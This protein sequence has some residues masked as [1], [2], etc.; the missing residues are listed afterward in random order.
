MASSNAS[1]AAKN[2]ARRAFNKRLGSDPVHPRILTTY[3]KRNHPAWVRRVELMADFDAEVARTWNRPLSSASQ[4]KRDV[5]WAWRLFRRSKHYEVVVAGSD[6]MSRIFSTLQLFFRRRRVPHL[7]I[8]WLCNPSG[9][10][11]KRRLQRIHLRWAILGASRAIVQGKDEIAAHAR[12]LGV[13]PSKFVFLPYHST[14]YDFGYEVKAGDY[15]FAG[16]DGNRDYRTMIEAVR[17]LPY[18]VVIAAL[19]REHFHGIQIPGNVEIFA[20]SQT[21][22]YQT[23]AG[24]ALVVVPMLPALLHPGGQQTWINAMTMGKPVIVAEDR[25]ARDYIVHKSTGWLTEPGNVSALREAICLLMENRDLARSLGSKAKE[26]ATQFSPER[27]FEAVFR[28][29]AECVE[30]AGV[31]R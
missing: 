1:A 18:R 24:A 31:K 2:H 26:A 8:D 17:G 5:L 22:F 4:I 9:G 14:L 15:I 19:S 23:M 27:F 3:S 11:L 28:V 20:L 6:R 13:S 30:E 29:A 12:E 16:G 10:H 7:Y 25:S 21:D